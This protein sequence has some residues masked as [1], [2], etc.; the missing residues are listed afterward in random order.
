[1][2][3]SLN[4]TPNKWFD[5]CYD[6]NNQ[7]MSDNQI[8]LSLDKLFDLLENSNILTASSV[9]L[10]QFKIK[11]NINDHRSISYLQTVSISD[12]KEL[13]ELFLEFW[14]IRDEDYLPL[15][16]SHIVYTFKI[17]NNTENDLIVSKLNRPKSSLT[18]IN[19][20]SFKGFKLPN[21][22]DFTLWGKVLTHTDTLATIKKYKSNAIY[23]INIFD[24]HLSVILK[25]NDKIVIE[26]TDTMIENGKLNSFTRKIKNQEYIFIDGNLIVKKSY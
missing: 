12:F 15:N 9:I 8:T 19:N 7:M 6:L 16:P 2:I 26:F 4:L 18:Q 11:L 3:K 17:H 13:N 5:Y 20:F 21:T 14:H 22:M 24:K 10:I 23:H 25:I 1:M